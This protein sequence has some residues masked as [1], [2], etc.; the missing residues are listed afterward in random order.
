MFPCL[1]QER[2]MSTLRKQMEADMA[3]RGLAYRTREAYL[4]SV[5]KLARHYGRRPDQISEAK[6]QR[7]LFY[8]LEE[9]KLAHSS[10]NIVCSGLGFFDRVTLKRWETEF[11]LPR[12]K[13]P[14]RLPQILSREDVAALFEK[15][16]NLKHRAFL[17][18]TYGGACGCRKR[19]SSRWA[20]LTATA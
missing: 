2:V 17:M 16:T 8:L 18:T 3:I 9:R 13:V 14:S 12:P 15:T 7:Y 10:C 5:A 20:T 1:I 4:D 6:V 11:C 19:V